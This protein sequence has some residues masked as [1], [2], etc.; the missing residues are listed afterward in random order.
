VIHDT[1]RVASGG[2][3]PNLQR[4]LFFR[5]HL[6]NVSKQ[7]QNDLPD[8]VIAFGCGL[9]GLFASELS[10]L[11]NVKLACNAKGKRIEFGNFKC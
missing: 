10:K 11:L 6:N 9:N 2:Y 1:I 3:N 5:G 4:D 8:L 7:Q